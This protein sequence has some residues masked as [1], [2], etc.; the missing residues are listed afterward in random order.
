MFS[1][2]TH[3]VMSILSTLFL[4]MYLYLHLS[5]LCEVITSNY[6]VHQFAKGATGSPLKILVNSLYETSLIICKEN[7]WLHVGT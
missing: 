4:S 2:I 5:M 3:I 7:T 6:N 1:S